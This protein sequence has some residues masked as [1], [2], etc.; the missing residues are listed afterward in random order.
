MEERETNLGEPGHGVGI[1][2]ISG[3]RVDGIA[4]SLAVNP[5]NRLIAAPS[6]A[7]ISTVRSLSL[8]PRGP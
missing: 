7:R 1:D 3:R 8:S 4:A 5:W 6:L 2:G